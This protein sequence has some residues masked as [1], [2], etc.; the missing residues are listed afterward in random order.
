MAEHFYDVVREE[1][2]QGK[3]RF[4]IYQEKETASYVQFERVADGVYDLP[5][6]YTNP[7]FR[8]RGLA[9]KVVLGAF[10][11]ARKESVKM[12]PSC[13]YISQTFLKK[14]P[15]FKENVLHD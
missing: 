1:V 6:T 8:G 14:Y 5:H 9:E 2:T 13:S 3:G 10:E 7:K 12:I 15:N 11:W 4:V